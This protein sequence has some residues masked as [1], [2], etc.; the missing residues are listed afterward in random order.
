M[1]VH[2]PLLGALLIPSIAFA[3]GWYVGGG[4]G[5]TYLHH[6]I[7]EYVRDAVDDVHH[8]V[9]ETVEEYPEAVAY[10]NGFSIPY[11][12]KDSKNSSA[13][14]LFAGYD[15][16]KRWRVEIA[17]KDFGT[18]SAAAT[19][20]TVDLFENGHATYEQYKLEGHVRANGHAAA[21][22]EADAR[23]ISVSALFN[24]LAKDRFNVFLRFGLEHVA[25]EVH[26]RTTYNYQYKYAVSDGTQLIGDNEAYNETETSSERF[27]VYSPVYGFGG[28]IKMKDDLFVRIEVERSGCPCLNNA[29]DFYSV[30][31]VKY[32]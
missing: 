1:N 10:L 13:Y 21:T 20:P 31:I 16:G 5:Q 8:T 29:V 2:I 3:D 30:G 11:N 19:T 7:Q 26:T 32:F 22:A 6:D 9:V 14:K 28:E 24:M 18:Y 17:Y 27:T 25:A 15:F 23:A 4:F 12:Y